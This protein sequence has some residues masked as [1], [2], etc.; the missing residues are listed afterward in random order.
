MH[1][2]KQEVQGLPNGY[3]VLSESEQLMV[4]ETDYL[5]K[6]VGK[7]IDRLSQ[8]DEVDQH[9]LNTAKTDLQKGFMG[10]T[11]AITKPTKF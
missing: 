1:N 4:Q 6:L 10:L 8:D 3:R 7:F 9:W 11:R 2:E 5:R